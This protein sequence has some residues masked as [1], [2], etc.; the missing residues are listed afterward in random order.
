MKQSQISY[1]ILDVKKKQ[2]CRKKFNFQ[3]NVKTISGAN[4]VLTT[5]FGSFMLKWSHSHPLHFVFT[6]Y[7]LLTEV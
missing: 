1:K 4:Y 5:T 7:F 2:Q 3:V 6:F